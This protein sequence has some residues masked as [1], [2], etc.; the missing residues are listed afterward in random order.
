[1]D[2]GE[3]GYSGGGGGR[4]EGEKGGEIEVGT[5]YMREK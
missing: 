5:K 2:L 3:R 4:L 1:M